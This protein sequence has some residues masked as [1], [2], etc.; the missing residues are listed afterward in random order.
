MNLRRLISALTVILLTGTPVFSQIRILPREKVES[1]ANPRLS[2]DSAALAFDTR[3]IIADP[4][5]EDDAPRTFIYSFC[6]AGKEPLVIKRLVSSCSCAAAVAVKNELEPGESSEIRV[7]Y[8]PKGH[9]GRFERKVFVYTE[10]EHD[11][12]AVLRLSVEVANGSDMSREWPVQMGPIRLR[13]QEVTFTEGVKA[14]E[15]MR[16]INLS[17]KPLML[18]CEDAFLPE[19]LS[20][21]TEPVTVADGEEG[22]MVISYDP[23]VTGARETMKVI[24][25]GL[26]LPPTKATITVKVTKE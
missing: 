15:R 10:S 18:S 7:T 20:F 2:R 6:N 9:P 24:L 19:C 25:K 3:H 4:M 8:N 13:R 17:G 5:S 21:R 16:F 12:A 14:A 1:V 11:P 22:Q 23:S 26:G